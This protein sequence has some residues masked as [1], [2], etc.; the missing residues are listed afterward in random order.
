M[1]ASTANEWG[2]GMD[3]E[4]YAE[5]QRHVLQRKDFPEHSHDPL[6]LAR[7]LAEEYIL[8]RDDGSSKPT[9]PMQLAGVIRAMADAQDERH[10]DQWPLTSELMRAPFLIP[11]MRDYIVDQWDGVFL[12]VGEDE[13]DYRIKIEPSRDRALAEDGHM[14]IATQRSRRVVTRSFIDEDGER[15]EITTEQSLVRESSRMPSGKQ[16]VVETRTVDG[17]A[18]SAFVIEGAPVRERNEDSTAGNEM[19]VARCVAGALKSEGVSI[20]SLEKEPDRDTD[21]D[22]WIVLRLG[23]RIGVQVT[24]AENQRLF[25]E[26]SRGQTKG[27][28]TKLDVKNAITK[29]LKNKKKLVRAPKLT[30]ALDCSFGLPQLDQ[31][32]AIA[33]AM[34]NV[35]SSDFAEVWVVNTGVRLAIRVKP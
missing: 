18:H 16:R 9:N 23:D 12:I 24:T 6:F 8:I 14:Q 20:E 11:A 1:N 29:A 27:E 26:A 21:V 10:I 19:A 33:R 34:T 15:R 32:A 13:F 3:W 22:V 28:Y 30:L 7:A 31:V 4:A 35:A 17:E 5:A 2:I 25:Q